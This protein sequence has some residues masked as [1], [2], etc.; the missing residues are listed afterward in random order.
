M[1]RAT[2]A[3]LLSA[4][5]LSAQAVPPL[6]SG[7]APTADKG[8]LEVWSGIHYEDDAGGVARELP[9]T[10]LVYGLSDR[11]ELTFEIP[12]LSLSPADGPRASGFGDGTLGT[13]YLFLRESARLPATAVSF[14]AKLDNAS[15]P[16]G[17]GSGSV[18]YDARLRAQ[19]AWGRFTGI[20][21]LGRT[22]AG[23]DGRRDSWFGS[24]VQE[25]QLTPELVLL[26]EAYLQQADTPDAPNRFAADAGFQ[27]AAAPHLQLHAAAGRSL[28]EGNVGGPHLRLFAGL[29]L[30]FAL[31]GE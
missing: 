27:M 11:Q 25:Y 21:N 22:F 28:R 13:K 20:A 18:D 29:K 30:E 19:K 8:H 7:D 16:Q 14:E 2:L 6:V 12:Y 17:L 23:G 24:L 15:A 10:E 5:S 4:C 1:R 26:S 9:T 31:R 3:A